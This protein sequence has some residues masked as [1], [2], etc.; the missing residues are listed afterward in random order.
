MAIDDF[1]EDMLRSLALVGG[2]MGTYFARADCARRPGGEASTWLGLTQL[3]GLEREME[4][5][6]MEMSRGFGMDGITKHGLSLREEKSET[7]TKFDFPKWQG[8]ASCLVDS[9]GCRDFDIV[10]NPD[11]RIFAD[12]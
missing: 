8:D 2:S 4:A 5:R 3:R 7:A 10:G 11:D 1:V 6:Y 9:L 12:G